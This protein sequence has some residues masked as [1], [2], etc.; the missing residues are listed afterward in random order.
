MDGGTHRPALRA[1][2]PQ[3]R[4]CVPSNELTVKCEAPITALIP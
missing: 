3:R 2:L 4:H 1:W